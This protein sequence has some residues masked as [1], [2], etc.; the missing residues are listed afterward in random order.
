MTAEP[1]PTRVP[2][3][4]P[5]SWSWGLESEPS[6]V[7][8]GVRAAL[9]RGTI[10]RLWANKVQARVRRWGVSGARASGNQLLPQGMGTVLLPADRLLRPGI[11]R[12][13]GLAG[14][15]LPLIVRARAV[16]T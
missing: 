2:T 6:R 4:F 7:T 8:A 13:R 10:R 5:T 16:P 12:L 11:A 9:S 1:G 14:P 3:I 15:D